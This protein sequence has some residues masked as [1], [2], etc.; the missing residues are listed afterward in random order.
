[1]DVDPVK[2]VAVISGLLA[3]LEKIYVYGRVAYEKK[4]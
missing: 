4:I 1:M 3:I 2:A